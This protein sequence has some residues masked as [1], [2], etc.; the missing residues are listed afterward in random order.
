M[1]C[2]LSRPKYRDS[3]QSKTD[4]EKMMHTYFNDNIKNK[5]CTF[6]GKPVRLVYSNENND[7][8]YNKFAYGGERYHSKKND[9][10]LYPDMRRLERFDWIFE[11]LENIETC[12]KNCSS[13]SITKD[14]SHKNRT[15][16]NC[17]YNKYR[18]LLVLVERET[19]Y[20]II[21]AFL[22]R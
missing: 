4:Y 14:R 13:L 3:S 21:T 9:K 7:K 19:E 16:I 11:I 5:T 18:I 2:F 8:C 15:I 10:P 20:L 22:V 17:I 1:N 12:C 6:K